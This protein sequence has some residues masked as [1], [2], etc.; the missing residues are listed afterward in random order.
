MDKKPALYSFQCFFQISR[1]KMVGYQYRGYRIETRREWSNWCVSIYPL[2]PD[3]PIFPRSTLHTLMP[4][5]HE[6]HIDLILS[7]LEVRQN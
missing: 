3:L 1:Q 6:E 7:S 2:Q 5:E 4:Q